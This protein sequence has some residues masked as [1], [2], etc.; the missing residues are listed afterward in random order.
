M[1]YV[2][3]GS[4]SGLLT[5]V[6][7]GI[8]FEEN[9][10]NIVSE[11]KLESELFSENKLIISDNLKSKKVLNTISKKFGNDVITYIYYSF[12]SE[13]ENIEKIIYDYIYL[14]FKENRNVDT[15]YTN[16]TVLH[17]KKT[18]DQVFYEKNK[19]IGILRFKLLNNNIFYA[20]I[21]PLYNIIYLIIDHFKDRFSNQDWLI[22]DIKRNI[23]VIYKN[24]VL[25][26]IEIDNFDEDDS[27]YEENEKKYQEMWKLFYNKIAISERKNL[28]LQRQY[29]PKRYWG[30]LIEKESSSDF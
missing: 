10:E 30:E 18:Y 13:K 11:N 12:L 14:F 7:E 28:K 9:P 17:I 29:L 2:Y 3:D 27:I 23:G 24:K 21:K 6:Y 22:H 15:F 19:F 8:L 4:F 25:E 16:Q 1:Q 26:F 5:A 20:Q